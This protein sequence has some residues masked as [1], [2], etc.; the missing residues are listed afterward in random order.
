MANI[1]PTQPAAWVPPVI[2]LPLL[3]RRTN[4]RL[5]FLYSKLLRG[6]VRCSCLT[7]VESRDTVTA[8]APT[9][10]NYITW[11]SHHLSSS[12]ENILASVY[13]S[14][15]LMK[16]TLHI[17]KCCSFFFL[18]GIWITLKLSFIWLI[19][20]LIYC[21]LFSAEF[22]LQDSS[23]LSSA[24]IHQWCAQ[25]SLQLGFNDACNWGKKTGWEG[26]GFQEIWRKMQK[27]YKHNYNQ[28]CKLV[29]VVTLQTINRTWTVLCS[30][31]GD[32]GWLK[33]SSLFAHGGRLCTPM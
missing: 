22:R 26:V 17:M 4:A 16:C 33:L 29:S 7:F 19:Y 2:V 32:I 11:P 27:H 15:G 8:V 24:A 6:I 9:Q 10:S 18:L 5:H 20:W 30:V 13:V 1:C 28:V 23:C 12:C 31:T 14:I 21:Q 3:S 25:T